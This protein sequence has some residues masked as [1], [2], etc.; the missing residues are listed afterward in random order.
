MG[1]K[2]IPDWLNS[3]LWSSNPTSYPGYRFR[4]SSPEASTESLKPEA[5]TRAPVPEPPPAR[6]SPPRPQRPQ[7]AEAPKPEAASPAGDPSPSLRF[8]PEEISRQSQLLAEVR[9]LANFNF[10]SPIFLIACLKFGSGLLMLLTM[11]SYRTRL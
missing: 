1:P 11:I 4:G 3:S 8:S 5:P 2:G 6:R 7:P 9:I 10:F